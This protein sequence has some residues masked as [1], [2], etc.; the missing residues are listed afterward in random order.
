MG[1]DADR[2]HDVEDLLAQ[3]RVALPGAVL[4]R[5]VPAVAHEAGQGVGERV[6]GERRDER[7]PAGERDHLGP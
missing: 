5:D 4:Q 6:E 2:R 1:A 7:H 3:G